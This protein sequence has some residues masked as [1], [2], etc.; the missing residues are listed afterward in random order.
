MNDAQRLQRRSYVRQA[1]YITKDT[2]L[3]PDLYERQL[4]ARYVRGELT[5]E[6]V[7]CL[8]EEQPKGKQAS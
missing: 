5:I 6:Q 7:I 3:A 1:M 8:V 2:P 4:L